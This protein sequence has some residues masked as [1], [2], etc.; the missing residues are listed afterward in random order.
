MRRAGKLM[1]LSNHENMVAPGEDDP[2]IIDMI[3]RAAEERR[4][5]KIDDVVA[6]RSAMISAPAAGRPNSRPGSTSPDALARQEA[7]AR[8]LLEAEEKA[9]EAAKRRAQVCLPLATMCMGGCFLA[10]CLADHRLCD[11]RFS[12]PPPPKKK[13][14]KQSFLFQRHV[15][16]NPNSKRLSGWL[17][18][19]C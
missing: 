4:M 11:L 9:L 15:F 3:F 14:N 5:A 1:T 17:R 16:W 13:K 7:A 18:L 6:A 19:R 12:H 8:V 10:L 2:E